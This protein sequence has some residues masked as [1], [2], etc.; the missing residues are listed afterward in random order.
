MPSPGIHSVRMYGPVPITLSAEIVV[1]SGSTAS[2]NSG[3]WITLNSFASPS[4][5]VPSGA[6][7][8]S[9]M[10]S[11]VLV[12]EAILFQYALRPKE[13]SE[14]STSNPAR[15]RSMLKTMSSTVR[16]RPAVEAA[17][18]APGPA[19]C[20]FT[21]WRIGSTTVVLSG[22]STP[23]ARSATSSPV[24]GFAKRMSFDCA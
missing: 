8:C 22:V 12:I 13:P 11:S 23:V 7:S 2:I 20:H 9:V 21:P 15:C 4:T 5:K 1:A 18:R 3:C 16:S 17:W 10:V 14:P 19:S 6:S 24:F